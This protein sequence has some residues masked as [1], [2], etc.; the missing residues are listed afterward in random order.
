MLPWIVALRIFNEG[1]P[2]WCV[3]RKD[4][5]SH[6]MIQ[7]IRAGAKVKTPKEIR[8]ELERKSKPKKV[9]RRAK[10]DLDDKK[11]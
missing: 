7:Q 4:T 11:S 1:S 9:R 2:S 3:P 8:E 6:R 5:P 10:I